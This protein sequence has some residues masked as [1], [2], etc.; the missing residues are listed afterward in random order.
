MK[1]ADLENRYGAVLNAFRRVYPDPKLALRFENPFQLLVAVILSAQCTDER[2]NSVTEELFKK[3]KG[4]EDIIRMSDEELENLIRPTGYYRQKA[5]SLKGCCEV[6]LKNYGGEI[7]TRMDELVKLPGVGRKTAA[8]V[9]GNAFGI[10]EGIAV[11]THVRRVAQRVGLSDHDTPEKIEQDLMKHIPRDL[12]TW[13]SNA[14]ILH[15]RNVCKARKP[16][17]GECPVK[18][19]CRFFMKSGG[20]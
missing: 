12:W 10:N 2:V 20:V 15:G 19:V 6:L 17:C 5:K 7:P 1:N 13:F 8:M 9:L 11:D 18:E 4:P 14:T 3:V 16:N